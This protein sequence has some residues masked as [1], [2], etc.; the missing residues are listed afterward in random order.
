LRALLKHLKGI[1]DKDIAGVNVPTA[2]PLVLRLEENLKLVESEYLGDP[3]E[4]QRQIEWVASQG[5]GNSV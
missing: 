4:V 1:S 5:R 2:V 3:A